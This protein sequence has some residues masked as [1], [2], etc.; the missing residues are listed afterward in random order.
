MNKR[1]PQ[2]PVFAERVKEFCRG[3][4][5]LTKRGAIQM[6]AVADMF[7][8]HEDTLRQFLQDTSRKRPHLN[9][10]KSIASVIG[11]SVV[12]FLESPNDPPPAAMSHELWGDMSERERSLVLSII[13]DIGSG[14]L[15][16]DEKEEL[17]RNF[18]EAKERM[19]RQKKMWAASR[20][21]G[22]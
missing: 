10:L 20:P 7:G 15:S 3:N 17:Y 8:V 6:E 12:E 5:Y 22:G 11:C 19:L 18:Q 16:L 21:G 1:W 2:Q 13:A 4:G 14:G 9:T